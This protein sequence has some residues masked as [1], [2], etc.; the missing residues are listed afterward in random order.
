MYTRPSKAARLFFVLAL[1]GG[2]F[3]GAE[4][5][6]PERNLTAD[7]GFPE[8]FGMVGGLRDGRILVADP[9]SQALMVI[10]L[11][12]GTAE[13]IGRVGAGS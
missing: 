12:A 2:L 9:L 3:V 7:A 8:A 1:F 13:T 6:V 10:D 11:Q 5:Q 4:A